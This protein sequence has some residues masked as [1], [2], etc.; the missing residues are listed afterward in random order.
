LSDELMLSFVQ[1]QLRSSLESPESKGGFI[2]QVD[3]D[4]NINVIKMMMSNVTP[5]PCNR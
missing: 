1:Q 3:Q 5:K 4:D 2:S